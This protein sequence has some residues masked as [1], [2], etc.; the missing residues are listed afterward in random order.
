MSRP[1]NQRQMAAY[2]MKSSGLSVSEIAGRLGVSRQLIHVW[3]SEMKDRLLC[4]SRLISGS[5]ELRDHLDEDLTFRS[6]R[7][8]TEMGCRTIDDVAKLS[9]SELYKQRYLGRKSLQ[10]VKDVLRRKGLSL[11]P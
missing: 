5:R 8:L 10:N 6:Y 7:I 9:E 4:K 11:R 1:V 2:D 3:L